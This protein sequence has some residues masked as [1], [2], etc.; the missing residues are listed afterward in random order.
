MGIVLARHVEFSAF[1]VSVQWSLISTH[2]N[3][4]KSEV[5]DFVCF[6]FFTIKLLDMLTDPGLSQAA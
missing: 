3:I 4:M 6:F 5:F 2:T 1:G